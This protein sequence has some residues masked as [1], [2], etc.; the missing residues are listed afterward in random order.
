MSLKVL[1]GTG[2]GAGGGSTGRAWGSKRQAHEKLNTRFPHRQEVTE[3]YHKGTQTVQILR[4]TLVFQ[5][6]GRLLKASIIR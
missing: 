6:S 4:I 1:S 3:A 2:P 5:S